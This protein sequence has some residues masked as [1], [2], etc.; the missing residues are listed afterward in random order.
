MYSTYCNVSPIQKKRTNTIE[1]S[2]WQHWEVKKKGNS[3][4]RPTASIYDHS[5]NI[6]RGS[7]PRAARMFVITPANELMA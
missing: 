5:R 4:R 1:L 2:S 3:R 7:A 6:V